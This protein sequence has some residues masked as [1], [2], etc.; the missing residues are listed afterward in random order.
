MEG[1][2]PEKVV[3]FSPVPSTRAHQAV[4]PISIHHLVAER[5]MGLSLKYRSAQPPLDHALVEKRWRRFLESFARRCVEPLAG[6]A[7]AGEVEV[8]PAA[9]VR[10]CIGALLRKSALVNGGG[11]LLLSQAVG[12]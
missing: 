5:A 7:G 8:G 4:I 2:V 10:V 11:K 9:I 6:S 12:G 3:S 1:F